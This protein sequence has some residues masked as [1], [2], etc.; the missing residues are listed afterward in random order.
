MGVG[1]GSS[2]FFLIVTLIDTELTS[3]AD[4]ITVAFILLV[5]LVLPFDVTVIVPFPE[6]LDGLIVQTEV[7]EQTADHDT[8]D[9]TFI[10]S[11]R[12][13]LSALKDNDD[14]VALRRLTTAP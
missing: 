6:P 11:V 12:P 7:A 2:P 8:L 1:P 9:W 14:G 3:F 4:I 13:L 5:V 10:V